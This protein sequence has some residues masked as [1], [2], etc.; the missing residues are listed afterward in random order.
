MTSDRAPLFLPDSPPTFEP[1]PSHPYLPMSTRLSFSTS[2]SLQA[3]ASFPFSSVAPHLRCAPVPPR[4][5]V[6]S[7]SPSQPI[8]PPATRSATHKRFRDPPYIPFSPRH[9]YRIIRLLDTVIAL[10]ASSLPLP[11]S[12]RRFLPV[13]PSRQHGLYGDVLTDV[14]IA[15]S[16]YAFGL[17]ALLRPIPREQRGGAGESAQKLFPPRRPPVAK[18]RGSPPHHAD[19]AEMP[20]R[21]RSH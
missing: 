21:T 16:A 10:A 18:F 9:H 13:S 17:L 2:L 12:F 11:R 19:G 6:P 15:C 3:P 8:T 7:H 4:P 20:G 14:V 5:G 1:S